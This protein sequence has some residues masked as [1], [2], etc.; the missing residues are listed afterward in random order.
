M[1]SKYPPHTEFNFEAMQVQMQVTLHV[2][3][4]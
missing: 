4:Q 1:L 3:G 2:L